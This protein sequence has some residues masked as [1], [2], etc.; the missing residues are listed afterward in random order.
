MVSSCK[1]VDASDWLRLVKSL[2]WQ[3]SSSLKE[4]KNSMAEVNCIHLHSSTPIHDWFT[5]QNVQEGDK[6]IHYER[7]YR[8]RTPQPSQLKSSTA[9]IRA[10][11]VIHQTHNHTFSLSEGG[12]VNT[13]VASTHAGRWRGWVSWAW[14]GDGLKTK[15][16]TGNWGCPMISLWYITMHHVRYNIIMGQPETTRWTV[17]ATSVYKTKIMLPS[18]EVQGEKWKKNCCCLFFFYW[19]MNN[20]VTKPFLKNVGNQTILVVIDFHCIKKNKNKK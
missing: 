17:Q 11:A 16:R 2:V 19:R 10:K 13:F 18:W 14:V 5:W 1:W 8:E 12:T 4:G 9:L 15:H 6:T 20:L 3:E 7:L